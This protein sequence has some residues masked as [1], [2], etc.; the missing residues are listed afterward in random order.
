MDAIAS[1]DLEKISMTAKL[2]AYMRQ[3]SD[4]PFAKEVAAFVRAKQAMDCLERIGDFS[5]TDLL[6]YA[7]LFEVRYKSIASYIG[8][9]GIEQV[10]ELASGFSLRGLAMVLGNQ[11]LTYLETDLASVTTLKLA[12]IAELR[13]TKT[14]VLPDNL[15]IGAADALDL[16]HVQNTAR[17]LKRD[18]PVVVVTEGLLQYLS[19]E[20][21]ECVVRNVYDL[22]STYGGIWITPDLTTQNEIP[23]LS[24]AQMRFRQALAKEAGRPLYNFSFNNREDMRS[25]FARQGFDIYS[26]NQATAVAHLTTLPMLDSHSRLAWEQVQS[27]LNLWVLSLREQRKNK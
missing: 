10:L 11:R 24:E 15:H 6:W 26:L 3:Y 21:I 23:L 5:F 27:K 9:S 12:L 19:I 14:T 25:F 2:T 22:L 1:S 20:E 7:P 13:R 16:E 4:I 18:Q 8:K 17:A